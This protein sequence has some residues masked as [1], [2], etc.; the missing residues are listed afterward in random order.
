MQLHRAAVA[1]LERERQLGR[2][3]PRQTQRHRP[4]HALS[5]EAVLLADRAVDASHRERRTVIQL[6]HSLGLLALGRGRRQ[7]QRYRRARPAAE[8]AQNAHHRPRN[9]REQQHQRIV[10]VGEHIQKRRAN[11]PQ[12]VG[13]S[14]FPHTPYSPRPAAGMGTL[15]STL[16]I[17]EEAEVSV[18]FAFGLRMTRWPLTSANMAATS[19]GTA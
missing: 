6:Q 7:M 13:Q 19:S 9:G 16:S 15:A 2:R 8:I 10:T 18:I 5:G 11:Q 1:A 12:A 4:A 17:T 3:P 14:R